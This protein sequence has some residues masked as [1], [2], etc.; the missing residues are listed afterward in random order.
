MC[1]DTIGSD[2]KKFLQSTVVYVD[3]WHDII[4]KIRQHSTIQNSTSHHST[5]QQQHNMWSN[6]LIHTRTHIHT[7]RYIHTCT[8][9]HKCTTHTYTHIYTHIH[10]TYTTHIY[11]HIHTYIH[12]HTHA[13]THAHT[14]V[15][16]THT[17]LILARFNSIAKTCYDKWYK[18]GVYV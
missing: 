16:H 11:I 13:H 14:H 2:N 7:C 8:Y 3:K 15:Q 6:L 4:H 12:V 10:H 17:W 9:I 18:S 1:S 5:A